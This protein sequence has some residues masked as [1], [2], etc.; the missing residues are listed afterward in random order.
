[1]IRDIKR[2]TQFVDYSGIS[3][4]KIHPSDIDAVLEF[5]NDVL[6]L[7][8]IKYRKGRMP[9]RQKILLE[10]ICD[11]W[12]NGKSVVLKVVHNVD[13]TSQSVKLEECLVDGIYYNKKWKY[14]NGGVPFV[15]VINEIGKRF[16]C[17]KCSF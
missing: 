13:D 9:T 10:R 3:N 6:V 5:G 2:A 4:G 1:M 8:E 14:H 15:K 11:S 12:H 17:E 7:I 16:N